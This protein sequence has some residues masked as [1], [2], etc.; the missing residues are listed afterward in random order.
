[1]RGQPVVMVIGVGWAVTGAPAATWGCVGGTCWRWAG[2]PSEAC[3]W[4]V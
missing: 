2:W 1:V 3:W 4:G